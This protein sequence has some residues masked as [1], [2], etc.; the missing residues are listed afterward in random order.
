MTTKVQLA[1]DALAEALGDD[2]EIVAEAQAEWNAVKVAAMALDM[3]G[4]REA[5]RGDAFIAKGEQLR[6]L[7]A[8]ADTLAAIAKE[9]E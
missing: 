4:I 1:L 7:D 9:T 2:H 8:A 6:T 5:W 3:V